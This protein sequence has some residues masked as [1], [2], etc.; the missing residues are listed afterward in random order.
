MKRCPS[1]SLNYSDDTLEF[2]LQDGIRLVGAASNIETPTAMR[3]ENFAPSKEATV[4]LPFKPKPAVPENKTENELQTN[5]PADLLKEISGAQNNKVLEIAPVVIAL[6]H[7]WWQWIYLDN[8][9][10][11]SF[12]AYF[13]SANFLMWL[14]LLAGGAAIALVSL[15][16]NTNK[17]FAI[18]SLV[19][20][21]INLLLFL[22]PRR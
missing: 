9:Y 10:Y 3:P 19:I 8:Q 20:L 2:C 6:A 18:L 7:N 21:A 13:F 16:R 15:K 22:V 11:Y 17:A 1:C 4:S 12:T 5:Q 14:L